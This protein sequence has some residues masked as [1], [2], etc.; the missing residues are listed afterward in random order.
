MVPPDLVFVPNESETRMNDFSIGYFASGEQRP[1]RKQC[2]EDLFW[3]TV[4]DRLVMVGKVWQLEQEAGYVHH[5]CSL[6]EKGRGN[7]QEVEPCYK[8]P[9]L[10]PSNLPF[11]ARF[12]LLKGP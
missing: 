4:G 7:I 8:T 5:L 1:G 9:K 10:T 2:Q 12:H 3:L 11:L 6:E